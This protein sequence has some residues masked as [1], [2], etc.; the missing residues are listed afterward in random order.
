MIYLEKPKEFN[1]KFDVVSCFFKKDDK[2]LLLLR[3]DSKPQGGTWGVPAGKVEEGESLTEA[4]CREIKE[5]TG[6]KFTEDLPKLIYTVFVKYPDY[7][8]V[9]HIFGF[10]V[11]NDYEVEIDPI[12]HKEFKWVTKEEALKMNFIQDLDSCINLY[13]N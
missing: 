3:Q 4:I 13:F 10:D 12:S 5:E 9:Y 8:F 1:S 6:F 7:D 2:F 11:N